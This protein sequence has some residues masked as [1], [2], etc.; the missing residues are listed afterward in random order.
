MF[1]DVAL[2]QQIDGAEA[3]LC[4]SIAEGVSTRQPEAGAV[5][6]PL[7]GGLVVF[8]GSG[9]PAN[10]AVGVGLDEPLDLAE[11]ATIEERWRERGEAMRVEL[12]SLALPSVG[13]ALTARDYRL[14]GFENVLGRPVAEP[15]R[16]VTAPS[17]TLEELAPD[18]I[19]LW[20]ELAVEGFAVPD[21]G[22]A[23]LESYPR[24]VLAGIFVDFARA[25]DFRRYLARVDGE[26]AG[27]ASL[28]LDGA[29]A[30]LCG[31]ATLPAYR[32]RGVQ[33]ALLQRRLTDAAERGCTLAVVTTQPGSKS[34]ANAQRRGFRVLYT[35]AVLVKRWS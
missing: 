27:S 23:P 5:V 10:K 28:R 8:A 29:I 2:A 15:E 6:T 35:R 14:I 19:G 24:D 22:P 4:A 21:E 9:S 30:Q 33:T 20:L 25:R 34:Q 12:S 11:L 31:A 17:I 26:P 32:R 13:Q 1:A 3:R 7:A 16:P 18:D